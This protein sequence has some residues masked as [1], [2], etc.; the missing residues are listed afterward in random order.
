MANETTLER[1]V[2]DETR[3]DVIKKGAAVTAA[4][5]L[6]ATGVAS[7]QDGGGADGG[8]LD[9]S[10]KALIG[11]QDFNPNARFTFV[12]GV[13][14]WTPTYGD[15]QD[16]WFS[17]YNTRMIRYLNEGQT[18]PLHVAQDANIGNYDEDLGFVVHPGDDSNQPQVFQMNQEW[19]PFGD[20]PNLL[21]V[22]CSPVAEDQEDNLLENEG[23][24]QE[25][26]QVDGNNTGGGGNNTSS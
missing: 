12:S 9:E 13:V 21:T 2:G 24:W 14:D 25:T 6:G 26:G 7:A 8:N 20:N 1:L 18:V 17:D 11:V 15:M 4:A 16:S 10:W 23:W 22:K 3:R 19:T 5:G